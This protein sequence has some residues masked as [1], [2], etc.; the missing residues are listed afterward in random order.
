MMSIFQK[1]VRPGKGGLKIRVYADKVGFLK[2]GKS[3][4]TSFIDSPLVQMLFTLIMILLS[5]SDRCHFL[6]VE[7]TDKTKWG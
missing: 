3:L 1:M 4:R 2:M 7:L 5:K 6:R